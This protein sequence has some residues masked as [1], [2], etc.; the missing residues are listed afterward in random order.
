MTSYLREIFPFFAAPAFFFF[1]RPLAIVGGI[2]EY[3][4]TEPEL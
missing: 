2:A 4:G 1:L 3:V